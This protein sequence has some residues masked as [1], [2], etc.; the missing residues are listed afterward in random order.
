MLTSKEKEL[1]QRH[2]AI[3]GDGNVVG[4]DNTVHVSKVDAKTYIA[5]V[6]DEHITFN[7]PGSAKD[8]RRR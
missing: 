2:I 3:D 7:C 5:E 4:N 8:S 6:K 1:L